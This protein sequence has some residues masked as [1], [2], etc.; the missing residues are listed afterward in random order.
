MNTSFCSVYD[1]SGTVWP[2]QP[3]PG[4]LFPGWDSK[5]RLQAQQAWN[6]YEQVESAD[7]ATRVALSNQGGWFP[8]LPSVFAQNPSIWVPLSSEGAKTMYRQGLL[9]HRQA[10][11]AVNW[12]PQR[13]RGI[14]TTPLKNIYPG[15]F[16]P[17]PS[18]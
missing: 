9:L 15:P 5:R 2:R 7:A 18:S 10:C 17:P 16:P 12:S 8:P 11:P 1:G 13:T 6:F 14:P 4:N 3:F